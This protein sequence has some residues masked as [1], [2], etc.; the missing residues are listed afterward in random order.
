MAYRTAF[1]LAPD[2][3][4]IQVTK[5][6]GRSPNRARNT[7]PDLYDYHHRRLRVYIPCSLFLD[8]GSRGVAKPLD[9]NSTR[10]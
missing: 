3:H 5:L 2:P 8:L 1:Q 6:G 10:V 4:F 7:S 9:I